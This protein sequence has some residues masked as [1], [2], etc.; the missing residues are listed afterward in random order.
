MRSFLTEDRGHSL[1]SNGEVMIRKGLSVPLNAP[2]SYHKAKEATKHQSL[3][4]YNVFP[5]EVVNLTLRRRHLPGTVTC[6]VLNAE[7]RNES[8][9]HINTIL[10]TSLQFRIP[11]RYPVFFQLPTGKPLGDRRS[12]LKCCPQVLT[13]YWPSH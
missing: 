5:A 6:G 4:I 12:T 2:Q 1:A 7:F 8:H 3:G 13:R 11:E 9:M 10:I